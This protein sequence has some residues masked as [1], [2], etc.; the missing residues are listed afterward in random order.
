MAV[1][2]IRQNCLED[3]GRLNVALTIVNERATFL[4]IVVFNHNL[5]CPLK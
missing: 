4:D 2:M 3:N 5:D 1:S